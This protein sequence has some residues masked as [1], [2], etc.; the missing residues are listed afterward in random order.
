MSDIQAFKNRFCFNPA[1]AYHVGVERECFITD[2]FG[3]IVPSAF[4]ALAYMK[5]NPWQMPNGSD[6]DMAQAVGYELSACQ[7]ET[8]TSPASIDTFEE[9]LAWQHT[10][11]ERSLHV[12]GLRPLHEEL[13]SESMPLDVYPDPTGRY[14]E[15]TKSM[16]REVLLAAC[17]V[18]GTHVHVGMP[19]HE[20]ALRIY[21]KVIAKTDALCLE[22]DHSAG[23]RLA[24]YR[25]VAPNPVPR[26]FDSWEHFHQIALEKGFAE[27]PRKCWTLIRIS[28]HGTIEFRMFGATKD[29]GEIASWVRRCHE[30]C[31]SS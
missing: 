31:I 16:P 20:T 17:R 18:T 22:G 30:L 1:M 21:N 9:E 24:T 28:V 19:D 6:A 26:P 29:V 5:K 14:A 25:V 8:R 7:I 11:L 3:A 15:I 27:D 12:L 10:Q 4:E 2:I 23:E 13:A